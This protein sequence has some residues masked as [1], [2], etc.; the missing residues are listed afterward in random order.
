MPQPDLGLVSSRKQHALELFAGLPRHYDAA[1]AVLSFGQD[2]RWRRT[3]VAVVGAERNQRVLDVATGTGMVARALV[4]ASGCQV[5]GVDQSRQM[6]ARAREV[7]TGNPSLAGRISFMEACAERLPFVDGEFDHVTFTYLLRYVDD[8]GATLRELS[9][10]LKPGGRLASL[11]FGVP[12]PA[13]ARSLWRGYT[14]VG[15]PALGRLVSR[16]WYDVGRFL[17][18][19]IEAFGTAYPLVRQRELWE[20]AGVRSVEVRRMSFGAGVVMSGTR[21]GDPTSP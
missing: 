10:V 7:T 5:V 14:R 19:S 18:P 4:R 13:P 11:E 8:P 1:G 17:G 21:D 2:P 3:L 15:L 6:L 12:A 20:Q 9:R 16:D